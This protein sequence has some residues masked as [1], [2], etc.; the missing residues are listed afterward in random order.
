MRCPICGSEYIPG[1]D[2][3]ADCRAPLIPAP[4]RE[5]LEELPD[6]PL[7]LAVDVFSPIE[8]DIVTSLLQ[9]HEIPCLVKAENQYAVDAS[10]TI[11]PLAR[12]RI[13]VRQSDLARA[14]DILKAFP[15][16]EAET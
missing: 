14:Q 1:I 16:P 8:A 11:G 4:P 3:C 13:L 15:M 9:A 6:D 5:P 2:E 7:V 10:Y 12:R